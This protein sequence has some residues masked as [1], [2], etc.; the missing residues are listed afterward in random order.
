MRYGSTH[1]TL[2]K[3]HYPHLKRKK[4]REINRD[5]DSPSPL[6]KKFRNSFPIITS[7]SQFG[8]IP[9]IN[10]RGH[11]KYGH[12]VGDLAYLMYKHGPDAL[13]VW[14][15]HMMQDMLRDSIT[16]HY[17]SYAANIFEDT[18]VELNRPK[19]RKSWYY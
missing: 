13:K 1:D 9:G 5:I 14:S 12:N 16:R 6:L 11:R 19:Y 7:H 17:G 8:R 18:L 2:T 10:Y 4:I 15:D 3:R